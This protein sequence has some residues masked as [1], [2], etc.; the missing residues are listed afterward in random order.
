MIWELSKIGRLTYVSHM[1]LIVISKI[2]QKLKFVV[3]EILLC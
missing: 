1:M 3:V 2:R